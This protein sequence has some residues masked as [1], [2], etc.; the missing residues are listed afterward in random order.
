MQLL[1]QCVGELNVKNKASLQRQNRC[2]R[3]GLMSV[4][5][6]ANIYSHVPCIVERGDSESAL[7]C[8]LQRH[9]TLSLRVK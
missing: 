4:T 3:S 8:A 1:E 6:K 5:A 7:L 9:F 2:L